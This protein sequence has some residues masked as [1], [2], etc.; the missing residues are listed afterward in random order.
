VTNGD[1]GHPSLGEFLRQE[2]E[3]RGITIE[4]VASATKISVRLLHL[5]ESDQYTELPAKPFIRGFVSSYA[6]FIGVDSK[7]ILTQF[8]DFL[9]VRSFERPTRDAGHSGYAFEKREGEQSRTILWIVMGGFLVFGAIGFAVFKPSLHHHKG[10]HLDK[11]K[12][13]NPDEASPSP[14]E[15]AGLVVGASPSVSPLASPSSSHSASP[16]P[17]AKPSPAEKVAPPV[18]AVVAPPSP[19]PSVKP[20]P[21]A[22]PSPKVIPPT[23]VITPSPSSSGE[24]GEESGGA[25]TD[26]VEKPDPLNSG[27]NLKGSEIKYKVVVKAD[28]DLW[29]KFQLDNRPKMKFILREGRILVLRANEQLRFQTS[30][31]DAAIIRINGAPGKP[32]TGNPD[33]VQKDSGLTLVLPK[34][35]AETIGEPFPGDSSIEGVTVPASRGSNPAPQPTE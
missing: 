34:Q 29:V 3:K 30:Q 33:A 22:K 18:V 25:P 17:L 7:E 21:K 32:L 8:G 14:S 2:R 26:K 24:S 12:E 15:S 10:S 5:L 16:S 19:K 1:Q 35:S 27:V 9:D 20:S 11:L 4:Q 23:P 6:R 13:A 31:P 28:Q